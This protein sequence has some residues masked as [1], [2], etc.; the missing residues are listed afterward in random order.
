[1]FNLWHSF[2]NSSKLNLPTNDTIA[3]D[4][5][6]WYCYVLNIDQRQREISQYIYKRDCDDESVAA[7]LGSTILRQ[8]YKN[9]QDFVPFEALMESDN[10]LLMSSDMKATNVRLFADVIPEEAHNK[11]L[12]QYIIGNDSRHLIFADNANSRILLPKFPL[13]E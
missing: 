2:R 9:T 7:S 13:Y 12:N 8:V 11:L 5:E 10:C 1:M 3:L 6:V 4:E